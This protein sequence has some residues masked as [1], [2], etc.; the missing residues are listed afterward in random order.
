MMELAELDE[1]EDETDE[2]WNQLV[3]KDGKDD[4]DQIDFLVKR[5]RAVLFFG[6]RHPQNQKP[7]M[8]ELAELDDEEDQRDEI[9]N[10]L[11]EK[12]GK[13]EGQRHAQNNKILTMELAEL[14]EKDEVD[15]KT[16]WLSRTKR[17]IWNE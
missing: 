11:A 8:M 2:I 15:E 5:T 1:E 9:W 12:D 17:M 13:N 3:E 4:L 16:S 10:Q 6:Q 7:L 14:D